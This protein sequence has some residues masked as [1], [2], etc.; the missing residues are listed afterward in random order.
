MTKDSYRQI[1]LQL[2]TSNLTTTILIIHQ[3]PMDG[4]I[5]QAKIIGNS[6]DIIISTEPNNNFCMLLLIDGAEDISSG[7]K[8]KKRNKY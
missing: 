1:L 4:S 7:L 3:K 2:S 5:H 6:A 8:V